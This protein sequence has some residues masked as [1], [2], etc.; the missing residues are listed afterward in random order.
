MLCVSTRDV[1][2][3]VSAFPPVCEQISFQGTL[4]LNG[5]VDFGRR[6]AMFRVA[7]PNGS[8][9]HLRRGGLCSGRGF[10]AEGL[11]SHA[12]GASGD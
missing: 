4:N 2:R 5:V 3:G 11:D 1:R 9:F 10:F 8:G 7:F 12:L 6:K